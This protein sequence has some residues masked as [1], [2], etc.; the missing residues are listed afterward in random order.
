MPRDEE[1]KMRGMFKFWR[2]KKQETSSL[3]NGCKGK[4]QTGWKLR[5]N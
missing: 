1:V 2:G 5:D 4:K 3:R